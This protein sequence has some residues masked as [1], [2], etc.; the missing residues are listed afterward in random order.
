MVLEGYSAY[1][2][3][4]GALA[5]ISSIKIRRK[6]YISSRRHLGALKEVRIN[7]DSKFKYCLPRRGNIEFTGLI[8]GIIRP[9]DR[10]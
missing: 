10:S 4:N 9:K 3:E 2:M 6:C 5:Q 8:P 1:N 7:L